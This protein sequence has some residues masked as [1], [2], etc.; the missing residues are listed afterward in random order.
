MADVIIRLKAVMMDGT[1]PAEGD[2]LVPYVQHLDGSSIDLPSIPAGVDV[3]FEIEF[4]GQDD[5]PFDMTGY[6][7]FIACRHS[8]SSSA[9]VFQNAVTM[10]GT[11]GTS[12]ATHAD[13]KDEKPRTCVYD[14]RVVEVA[15]SKEQQPIP[16]SHLVITATVG[17]SDEEVAQPSAGILLVGVVVVASVDLLPTD[18]APADGALAA[19]M[20]GPALAIAKNGAWFMGDEQVWP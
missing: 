13:T 10:S 12:F 2:A 17:D 18:P 6:T 3:S 7:G 15:T 1:D 8:R 9:A 19:V 16:L 4:V 5:Q 14:L 11:S 20:D